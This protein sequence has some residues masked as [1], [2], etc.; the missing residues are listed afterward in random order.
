MKINTTTYGG[1]AG[2]D[3]HLNTDFEQYIRGDWGD[4]HHPPPNPFLIQL[5]T[6]SQDCSSSLGILEGGTSAPAPKED[7]AGRDGWV[8]G[9]TASTPRESCLMMQVKPVNQVE[10]SIDLPHCEVGSLSPTS[11]LPIE[12]SQALKAAKPPSH[13]SSALHTSAVHL[14]LRYTSHVPSVDQM[15]C[16]SY[17]P[18]VD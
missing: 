9:V 18:G 3:K 8:M 4:E 12:Q 10:F 16:T 15:G 13:Q 7:T 2:M 17:A 1:K 11:I 14:A 5:D 6:G